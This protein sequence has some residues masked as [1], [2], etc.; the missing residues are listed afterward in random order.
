MAPPAVRRSYTVHPST[1]PWHNSHAR[2]KALCGPVG[3]GKST[4][5]C[6][7]LFFAMRESAIPLEILVLR[8][9]YRQLH[10][11]TRKTW[12]YWFPEHDQ[13]GPSAYE[14]QNETIHVTVPN[15]DG[16][17]LTHHIAFRHARRAEEASNL[18][19]T[20][21]AIIWFEEPVPAYQMDEGVVGAGLPYEFFTLA[22]SRLRQAGAHRRHVL[23]TFN[24]PHRYH[25]TYKEFWRPECKTAE[26]RDATLADLGYAFVKQPAF[27]NTANL[28]AGYYH[29]LLKRFDPE[30]ARRFIMGEVVTLY[31]GERVFPEVFE[32]RHMIDGGLDVIPGVEAVIGF[33]F[34]LTPAALICQVS[35]T[36]Q[37]RIYEEIQLFNAGAERLC[38]T[39]AGTLRGPRFHRIT[40]WRCWADPAG[41]Q[42]A[43]TDEKTMYQLLAAHGFVCRP[44]AIDYESRRQAVKQRF[45]RLIPESA[46]AAV[47]IDMNA[48]P[49]LSEGL[50]GGYR[51]PTSTDFRQG[52]RPL[53]NQFS[54]LCDALQYICTGEYGLT[55]GTAR[56]A[57]V[58]AA[59]PKRPRYNPLDTTRKAGQGRSWMVH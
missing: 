10:D 24:P 21:Y 9:S 43:Q 56:M 15:V 57:D 13:G 16:L 39:L 41:Q 18:L 17:V 22:M 2:V 19:S 31:P 14:K 59:P 20:E 55:D 26:T 3:S 47:L 54:H 42:R 44:G 38:E 46:D 12:L 48:C 5:A 40:S 33:D 53:K 34:G 58:D 1:V 8:E 50:L 45:S 52:I 25:W 36:G 29:E 35:P 6:M 23:L 7:E 32:H 37:L 49:I 4:A 28:P 27:E 51:Y 11:S 30:L